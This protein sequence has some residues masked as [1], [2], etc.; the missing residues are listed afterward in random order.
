MNRLTELN[1]KLAD[2]EQGLETNNHTLKELVREGL[3]GEE[4][5]AEFIKDNLDLAEAINDLKDEIDDIENTP[6]AVLI[7]EEKPIA[8]L[9][10]EAKEKKKPAKKSNLPKDALEMVNRLYKDG[11]Y[12]EAIE[13]LRLLR[14]DMFEDYNVNIEFKNKIDGMIGLCLDKMRA[15][16]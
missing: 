10:K 11:K 8:Q 14:F 15:S 16:R 1:A 5:I 3:I 2:L 13:G 9:I 6:V 12:R 7:E 4:E